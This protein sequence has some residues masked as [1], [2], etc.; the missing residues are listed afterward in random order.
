MYVFV[1]EMSKEKRRHHIAF[2]QIAC[3]VCFLVTHMSECLAAWWWLGRECLELTDQTEPRVLL[4]LQK[5]KQSSMVIFH[6]L[7][8][9]KGGG[10]PPPRITFDFSRSFHKDPIFCKDEHPHALSQCYPAPPLPRLLPT[11]CSLLYFMFR[12]GS[13]PHRWIPV[14][15]KRHRIHRNQKRSEQS[16]FKAMCLRCGQTG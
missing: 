3:L 14:G 4:W 11:Q 15:Q 7:Y 8:L 5:G 9:A 16:A 1:S 6:I 10:V 12:Y 2:L 13:C